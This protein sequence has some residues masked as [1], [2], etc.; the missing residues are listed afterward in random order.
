MKTRLLLLLLLFLAVG[1]S[2]QEIEEET[3]PKDYKLTISN[4]F[5]Q[6]F[7]PNTSVFALGLEGKADNGFAFYVEGGFPLKSFGY[8]FSNEGKMDWSYYK[9]RLGARYYF[10]PLKPYRYKRKYRYPKRKKYRNFVGIEGFVGAETFTRENSYFYDENS[11]YIS[12][13]RATVHIL[14]RSY[15][16]TYGREFQITDRFISR[17]Y[18]G[19]GQQ[20]NDVSHESLLIDSASSFGFGFFGFSGG[21]EY[22]EGAS[23]VPYFKLGVDI[24][25]RMFERR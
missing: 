21:S 1:L 12:Y 25:L 22:R 15:V 17:W 19:L 2:A 24:G 4:S 8:N 20:V 5:L 18:V 10:E 3:P 14:T 11:N 9:T 7:H 23:R 16:L 6:L 13:S